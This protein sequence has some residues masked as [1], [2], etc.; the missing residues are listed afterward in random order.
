MFVNIKRGMTKERPVSCVP[1][2]VIFFLMLGFITQL[3]WHASRPPPAVNVREVPL[4]PRAD[5]LNM[6]SLGEPEALSRM[7]MLWLQAFDNQPGVSIPFR[8]LDYDRVIAW[9]DT[10]L[11]LDPANQYPLLSAARVYSCP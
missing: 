7:L 9:L 11:T 6:F 10:I 1:G 5:Y 3:A 8:Q 2:G 4:S